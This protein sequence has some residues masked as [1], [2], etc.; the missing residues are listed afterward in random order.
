MARS[1]RRSSAPDP[2]AA[3]AADPIEH[4]VGQEPEEPGD[5]A[6]VK[7][8]VKGSGRAVRSAVARMADDP[9]DA[10]T[11]ENGAYDDRIGDLMSDA[12]NMVV[13]TRSAPT[14][15][16]GKKLRAVREQFPCPIDMNRIQEEIFPYYG[17]KSYRVSVHPATTNGERTVLGAFTLDNPEADEPWFP[18]DVEGTAGARRSP[19]D[20]Y[21]DPQDPTA[22]IDPMGTIE[23]TLEQKARMTAKQLQVETAQDALDSIRKKPRRGAGAEPE[24]EDRITRLERKI[25]DGDIR[26]R[27]D[28]METLIRENAQPR[29]D[30]TTVLIVKMIESSQNQSRDFMTTMVNM[31]NQ[32]QQQILAL[33]NQRKT[34][35]MDTQLERLIKMKTAFG[36]GDDRVRDL[37]T[38]LVD[39]A[40]DRVL[41]GEVSGEESDIKFAVKQMVP[42][43]K[44]YVEKKID[45]EPAGKQLSREEMRQIYM[46]AARQGAHE[47]F[48]RLGAARA[49]PQP[50][51]P[52]PG[53]RRP[54]RPPQG[55]SGPPPAPLPPPAHPAPNPPADAEPGPEAPPD[56]GAGEFGETLD[57]GPVETPRSAAPPGP[58]DVP[59]RGEDE[60][61]T[62]K[63]SKPGTPGYD[64]TRSVNF[65]LDGIMS[66][67]EDRIPHEHVEESYAVGDIVEFLDDD[68]HTRLVAIDSGAELEDLLREWADPRVLGDVKEAARRDPVVKTWLKRVV[69]TAQDIVV[70][71]R[72]APSGT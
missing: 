39:M 70:R 25:E 16:R 69:L 47:A 20:G 9:P 57:G 24:D 26:T 30:D 45:G 5:D 31:M 55:T 37:E 72:R 65:V 66:E 48:A 2:E 19:R 18:E 27:M 42:V 49:Q 44:Q 71:R 8:E 51:P 33:V 63:P 23:E 17:G 68:I 13:V 40:F 46:D 64:R 12:R 11:D 50:L 60:G 62:D 29:R 14:R 4:D 41:E 52:P 10:P 6:D 28:R 58:G 32:N 53:T 67:I 1:R 22:V 59:G 3:A 7:L 54:V 21:D 61:P 34:D 38:R 15:W 56:A 36:A 35:D 43:I